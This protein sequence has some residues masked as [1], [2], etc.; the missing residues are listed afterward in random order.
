[1]YYNRKEKADILSQIKFEMKCSGFNND[2]FYDLPS[3]KILEYHK[4]HDMQC[5]LLNYN[6]LKKDYYP[7]L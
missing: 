6:L 1:M 3:I 7:H 5:L 2:R 4:L